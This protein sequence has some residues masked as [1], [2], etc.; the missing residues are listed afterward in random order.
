MAKFVLF[1]N[2]FFMFNFQKI[3]GVFYT[4]KD[5]AECTNAAMAKGWS[6]RD[7][8]FA[9]A[10][11]DI[12]TDYCARNKGISFTVNQFR[13]YVIDLKAHG[14]YTHDNRLMGNIM[15]MLRKRK[16]CKSTGLKIK[17]KVGHG[18]S[19]TVWLAL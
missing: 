8:E 16:V 12:I 3:F 17:S 13:D 2:P 4:K 7:R 6:A 14:I 18:T 1:H 19:L 11:I 9:N 10:M 5:I 15:H